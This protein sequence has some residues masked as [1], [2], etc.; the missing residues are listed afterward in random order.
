MSNCVLVN[1][2]NGSTCIKCA[3]NYLNVGGLC[4]DKSTAIANCLDYDE[5]KSKFASSA[6]CVKCKS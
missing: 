1:E 2:M 4:L 6:H 5:D 3:N